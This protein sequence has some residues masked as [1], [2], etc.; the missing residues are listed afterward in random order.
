M[1]IIHISQS[2]GIGA[3]GVKLANITRYIELIDD[4]GG[5]MQIFKI[6]QEIF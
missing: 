2:A 5:D 3:D 6:C 1:Y 4:G